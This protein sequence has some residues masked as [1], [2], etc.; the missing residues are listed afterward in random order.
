MKPTREDVLISR[1]VDR[2]EAP[3]DWRELDRLAAARDGLW[4]EL[5]QALRQD[6][7]VR[8]AV[9]PALA[10]ADGRPL[11]GSLGADATPVRGSSPSAWV[12]WAAALLVAALWIAA[13]T[14][15]NRPGT[16]AIA[17][18]PTAMT[19][20]SPSDPSVLR[21]LSR[22]VV[23]ARPT[24]DGRAVEVVYVRRVLERAVVNELY[25]ITKDEHGMPV[26]SPIDPARFA[27]PS[28]Y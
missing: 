16:D 27:R 13:A 8:A 3:T 21:E 22:V 1:V 6:A 18:E 19:P 17:V 10:A 7:A 23:R 24:D 25:E 2:E 15:P 9:A 20:A 14:G 4:Q 11:P 5:L 28:S 12:G 26:P